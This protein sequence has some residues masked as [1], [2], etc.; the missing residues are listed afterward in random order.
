M[1][2]Q[3]EFETGPGNSVSAKRSRW[4]LPSLYVAVALY[5]YMNLFVRSRVPILLSG[6]QLHFWMDGLRLLHGEL[7]Y[8]DRLVPGGVN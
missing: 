4:L 7:P 6:D 2:S 8:R 5:L 1:H 3:T